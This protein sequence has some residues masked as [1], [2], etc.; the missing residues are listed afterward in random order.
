MRANDR[1]ATLKVL[2]AGPAECEGGSLRSNRRDLAY[3]VHKIAQE[4]ALSKCCKLQPGFTHENPGTTVADH[5]EIR[6][7]ASNNLG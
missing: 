7:S 3:Y 4:A 6:A 5:A 1:E 2:T